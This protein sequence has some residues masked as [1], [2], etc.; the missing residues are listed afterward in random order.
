MAE[1]FGHALGQA[2]DAAKLTQLAFAKRLGVNQ[3]FLSRVLSGKRRPPLD[4]VEG[5]L[6]ELEITGKDRE[7]LLECAHLA[8]ATP[9]LRG[10]VDFLHGRIAYCERKLKQRAAEKGRPYDSDEDLPKT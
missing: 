4:Q 3:G 10:R 2:L 1:S 6:E 5:W 9:W 8:H 7:H